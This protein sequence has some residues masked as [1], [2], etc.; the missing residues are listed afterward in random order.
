MSIQSKNLRRKTVIRHLNLD[1]FLGPLQIQATKAREY[2]LKKE[3]IK[4]HWIEWENA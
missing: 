1:I 4:W 3:K 2:K